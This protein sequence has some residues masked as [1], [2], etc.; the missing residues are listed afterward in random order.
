MP[1][2]RLYFLGKISIFSSQ[3]AAGHWYIL[4]WFLDIWP[5][6]RPSYTRASLKMRLTIFPYEIILPKRAQRK[7]IPVSTQASKI[8]LFN[9]ARLIKALIFGF[10]LYEWLIN[11]TKFTIVRS[12]CFN[13]YEHFNF[14]VKIIVSFPSYW[15]RTT[16]LR[17]G[18]QRGKTSKPF[19]GHT[20]TESCSIAEVSHLA[21]IY[22]SAK[23]DISNKNDTI[24]QLCRR[25]KSTLIQAVK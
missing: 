5:T 23:Y 16:Y 7:T 11:A 20:R 24:F 15:K 19:I 21:Y 18:S 25:T 14:F 2:S 9:L 8:F 13:Y 10:V 17:G 22:R 12:K 1:S 6:S 3:P 4:A